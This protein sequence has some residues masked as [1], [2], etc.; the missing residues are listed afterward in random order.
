[1]ILVALKKRS[2][3]IELTICLFGRYLVMGKAVYMIAYPR[4]LERATLEGTGRTVTVWM[5]HESDGR[6]GSIR[7]AKLSWMKRMEPD[8][9]GAEDAFVLMHFDRQ[10]R[11]LGLAKIMK[12]SG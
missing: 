12:V 10:Q 1:V 3:K 11:N 9:L 5:P 7:A 6:H 8:L 4:N 2:I